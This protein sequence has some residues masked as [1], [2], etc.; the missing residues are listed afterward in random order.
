MVA[1]E[2]AFKGGW[3]ISRKEVMLWK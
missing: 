2:S 3:L 1:I